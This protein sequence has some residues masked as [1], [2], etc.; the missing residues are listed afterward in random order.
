MAIS[1]SLSTVIY[2]RFPAFI[3][4]GHLELKIL[5]KIEKRE[6]ESPA[7]GSMK[8]ACA[9]RCSKLAAP[10]CFTGISDNKGRKGYSVETQGNFTYGNDRDVFAS[11]GFSR[12]LSA[13]NPRAKYSARDSLTQ[14][15]VPSIDHVLPQFYRADVVEVHRQG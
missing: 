13:S 12:I 7:R 5:M 3:E 9:S 10:S 6:G 15:F 2:P 8:P 14:Q 1:E 4:L 11:F